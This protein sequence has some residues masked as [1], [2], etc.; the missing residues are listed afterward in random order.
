MT[1]EE[2]LGVGSIALDARAFRSLSLTALG[3]LFLIVATAVGLSRLGILPNSH[4]MNSGAGA[5][6]SARDAIAKARDS[7]TQAGGITALL[8]VR[9][10]GMRTG[11]E[12]TK[13]KRNR[14][15]PPRHERALGK[16]RRPV[17]PP[18]FLK[19]LAPGLEVADIAPIVDLNPLIGPP[20]QQFALAELSPGGGTG[21]GPGAPGLPGAPGFPIG[22][23]GGSTSTP[24][25]TDTPPPI[26]PSAVPEPGTWAMMLLGFFAMGL[27]V[28][29]SPVSRKLLIRK[30]T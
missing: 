27:K 2:R 15:S 5:L 9:S 16:I 25:I 23:G 21:G 29:R 14:V 26:P 13:T 28:R 24:P 20:V 30:L 11:A 1:N 22:G 8:A 19:A 18:E 3:A 7:L 10:P 12:L 17:L 6:V 4:V